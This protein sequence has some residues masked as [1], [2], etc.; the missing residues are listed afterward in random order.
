VVLNAFFSALILFL[1]TATDAARTRDLFFLLV[2]TLGEPSWGELAAL[3]GLLA[4]G[5]PVLVAAGHRMNLLAFGEEAAE[6]LGVNAERTTWV[7]V[8]AASLVTA[9][10]VAFSG[11]VGFVGL[12]VPH[13]LRLAVGPDHRLLVPTSALGGAAFLVVADACARSALATPLPV[14]VVTALAGGPF[15][16]V[17]LHRQLRRASG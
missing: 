7:V 15:F 10:A 6:H 13:T 3:V 5:L 12:I 17:L 2:G 4:V 14:G 1:L 8:G 16:L 9:A 11:I